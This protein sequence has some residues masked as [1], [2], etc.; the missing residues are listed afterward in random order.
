MAWIIEKPP[1]QP[2]VPHRAT[3]RPRGR[4]HHND[5]NLD[6]GVRQTQR[7][8]QSHAERHLGAVLRLHA[9]LAPDAVRQ[10]REPLL[11]QLMIWLHAAYH[12]NEAEAIELVALSLHDTANIDMHSARLRVRRALR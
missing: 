4:P 5:T 1:Q 2:R 7:V 3:G 6:A 8:L 12:D 11:F 9:R 10:L